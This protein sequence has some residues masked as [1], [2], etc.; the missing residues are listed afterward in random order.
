M[1]DAVNSC[2]RQWRR[3]GV[4]CRCL[5]TFNSFYISFFFIFVYL[6]PFSYSHFLVA[7]IIPFLLSSSYFFPFIPY[8][9]SHSCLPPKSLLIHKLIPISSFFL[10][11]PFLYSLLIILLLHVSFSSTFSTSH[12]SQFFTSLHSSLLSKFS[13]LLH[14][15]LHSLVRLIHPSFPNPHSHFTFTFP[16]S[17]E[18]DKRA[19]ASRQ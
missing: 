2:I 19:S 14:I 5:R 11:F 18:S 8:F 6:F 7:D 16:V 13:F 10:M 15:L 12:S 4:T 1:K 9:S 3:V 17:S